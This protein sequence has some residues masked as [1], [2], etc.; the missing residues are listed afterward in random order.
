MGQMKMI[1]LEQSQETSCRGW[2]VVIVWT[3]SQKL[4]HHYHS[5]ANKLA[6]LASCTA[7]IPDY[8]RLRQ[9]EEHWDA[10]K[11]RYWD[12]SKFRPRSLYCRAIFN[13]QPFIYFDLGL[14]NCVGA[15]ASSFRVVD[16]LLIHSLS[17]G[18]DMYLSPMLSKLCYYM[19]L[20]INL[21]D[22]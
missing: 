15:I 12:S 2:T 20:F 9:S 22:L 21:P 17:T 6:V 7:S 14:C 8:S 5:A 1:S 19:V 10:I 13:K 4:R 11:I 3:F 16:C 18:I